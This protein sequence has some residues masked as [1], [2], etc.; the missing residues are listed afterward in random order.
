[1][2]DSTLQG[3]RP[4]AGRLLVR[5]VDASEDPRWNAYVAAHPCGS[6]YLH[7]GWLHALRREYDGRQVHLLC[8]D[9]AGV[10]RGVLP[11]VY[12]R[13]VPLRLAGPT[14]VRRLA[15]LPRTPVG[16]PLVTGVDVAERL[17]GA[18]IDVAR[19]GGGPLLQFRRQHADLDG[20]PGVV[21]QPW[22]PSFVLRL[23]A[24]TEPLVFG[25]ARNHRRLRWAVNKAER[26]GVKVRR[27][28]LDDVR[29]WYRLYL[30]TMRGHVVPPRPLRLFLSL[31]ELPEL[32]DTVELHVAEVNTEGRSTLIAGSFFLRFGSTVSY[33]FNGVDPRSLR[34]RA[35]DALQWH[36][37]HAAWRDGFRVYDLGEVMD[38]NDSLSDFKRKW[39]ASPEMMFRY[40]HPPLA[41]AARGMDGPPK[42]K[43]TGHRAAVG[44][45][46][47]LPLPVTAALGHAVWNFS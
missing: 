3:Q 38:E 34:L 24:T 4:A 5:E 13:G 1:V 37:I 23:P 22:R 12:T 44:V 14:R 27:G 6:G 17:V 26:E 41:E 15:S 32:A 18:A 25:D 11:L 8:E 19:E 42:A 35:N 39:G 33:A 46:N 28:D 7:S 36:A 47:R 2:T 16:G 21:G 10:V 20:L 45:W 29:P 40:Y 30:E 31:L 9:E 43:K